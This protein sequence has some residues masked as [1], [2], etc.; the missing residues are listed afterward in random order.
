MACE[1]SVRCGGLSEFCCGVVGCEWDWEFGF[2]MS[3][4]GD[5]FGLPYGDCLECGCDWIVPGINIMVN[6]G[7]VF[8]DGVELWIN[9]ADIWRAGAEG[10]INIG[11]AWRRVF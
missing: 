6:V 10:W 11:N 1:G 4:W 9:I 2:C 5:C 3:G 8:R 7:D